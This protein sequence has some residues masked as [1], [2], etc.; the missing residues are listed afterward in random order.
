LLVNMAYLDRV[1][2]CPSVVGVGWTLC[3]EIQLYLTY[4]LLLGV[5]QWLTRR[6]RNETLSWWFVFGPMA[7]VSLAIG[8]GVVASPG[9]GLCLGYWYMFF[10]GSLAAWQVCGQLSLRWFAVACLLV[11]TAT[12]AHWDVRAVAAIGVAVSIVLVGKAG[13]LGTALDWP[14]LQHLGRI[15]Y[16]L[17]LAHTVVGWPLL[18]L[19]IAWTDG[20]PGP[21]GS[22]LLFAVACGTSLLAAELLHA[23]V[24]RPSLALSKRV[25]RSSPIES[26]LPDP[27]LSQVPAAA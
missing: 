2:D 14:W 15:S 3:L 25:L 8:F 1:L 19:G 26:P 23:F 12:V 22:C 11:S 7:F 24:E 21:F 4:I 20:E 27:G 16:S 5:A 10:L 9:R 6:T 17:Y 18:A 13:R